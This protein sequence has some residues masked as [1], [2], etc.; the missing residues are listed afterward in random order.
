MRTKA[1]ILQEFAREQEKLAAPSERTEPELFGVDPSVRDIPEVD[2]NDAGV[3]FSRFRVLLE[4]ERVGFH[5][6]TG[7]LAPA[8][9]ARVALSLDSRAP[10]LP[11]W[12]C[13]CLTTTSQRM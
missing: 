13:Q 12:P 10:L 3:P 5:N 4:Q 11:A 8:R 9:H 6:V 2:G 7:R 1:A